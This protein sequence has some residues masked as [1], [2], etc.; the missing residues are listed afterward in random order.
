[1]EQL[2]KAIIAA[3]R[4]LRTDQGLLL[5]G[6]P[7]EGKTYSL[8]AITRQLYFDGWDVKRTTWDMLCLKI[9]DTFSHGESEIESGE[10]GPKTSQIG[11]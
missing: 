2:P 7:G 3:A 11:A 10:I 8:C 9:R 4:S 5:W 1:M 6:S